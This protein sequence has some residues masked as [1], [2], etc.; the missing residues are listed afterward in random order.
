MSEELAD[1]IAGL[2]FRWLQ[3]EQKV[4]KG[5]GRFETTLKALGLAFDKL[6]TSKPPIS[7]QRR[8]SLNKVC[9]M[10][11]M[12]T[13]A[14]GVIINQVVA[15]MPPAHAYL[16]V[17]VWHGFSL[18]AGMA[19][20]ADKTCIGID[21]F[22]MWGGPRDA[23]LR[24]FES[25]KGPDHHFFEQD[26]EAYLQYHQ[27]PLGFYF[28]DGNHQYEHQLK[29]LKLAEPCMAPGCVIMVDDTNW[30]E[31]RQATYDFMES[32]E[33]DYQVLLDQ[34]TASDRVVHQESAMHPTFWN[35]LMLIQK[36]S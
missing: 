21:N 32:C 24:R 4:P 8:A 9:Q 30:Q 34:Q 31:P 13:Y 25:W 36:T 22:S 11:R 5:F 29:G 23:F 20:N 10:P 17:G 14:V 1:F 15:H 35:G 26:Y 19:G 6:N 12:S 2:N 16:N 3:P 33:A 27:Q 28:Y 18:L 7:K